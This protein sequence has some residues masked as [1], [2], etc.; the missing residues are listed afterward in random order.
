MEVAASR[1]AH[2]RSS[3]SLAR[4]RRDLV[5]RASA[6][7]TR[8]VAAWG[9][10]HA[11]CVART[12]ALLSDAA[13]FMHDAAVSVARIAGALLA[14]GTKRGRA[15]ALADALFCAFLLLLF[16]F[17]NCCAAAAGL[18]SDQTGRRGDV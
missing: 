12:A 14:G 17:G 3:V 11:G 10:K 18:C 4:L 9:K 13:G 2:A 1:R 7:K 6:K 8:A 5:E 16:L 15:L